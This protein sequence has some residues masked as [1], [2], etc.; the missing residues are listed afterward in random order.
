MRADGHRYSRAAV[1]S[2]ASRATK[3]DSAPIALISGAGKTTAVFFSIP[4][5][6]NVYS[7][8]SCSANGWAIMVSEAS[9]SAAAARASPSAAMILARF[10]RAPVVHRADAL[11]AP[12]GSAHRDFGS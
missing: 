10:S 5:S 2:R 4:N 11:G 9:P 8:R 3:A 7:F 6:S 1:D 12:E